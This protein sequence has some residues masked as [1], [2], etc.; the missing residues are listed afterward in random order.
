[1]KAVLKAIETWGSESEERL[2]LL[3]LLIWAGFGACVLLVALIAA[4]LV[5]PPDFTL[6]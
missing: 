5:L 2:K 1:M 3:M 6:L 4:W